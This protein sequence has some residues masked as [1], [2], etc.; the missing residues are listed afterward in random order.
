[1]GSRDVGL[2]SRHLPVRRQNPE[3]P[4]MNDQAIE[5]EI[6]AKGLTAARVTKD[7]IDALMARVTYV[8]GRVEQT[9]S[10]IVH[11]FLDGGFLLASGHSAC[12]SPENF[13]AELGF[14]MARDQAEVK[15]RDQL[16]LL[17]GY[18]LRTRLGEPV[19]M[20][21]G[22]L[23][24]DLLVNRF[25]QWPVPAHIHPDGTPGQPGR[26]GTNLLDAVT[27]GDM[28]RHVLGG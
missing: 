6:Q 11:A 10:T 24:P 8:G 15:A 13:N 7:H 28:L 12:V 14:N 26:T 23:D 9:T 16:W 21:S 18:A 20:V 19:A 17:E 4:T 25:L 1:M 27:A 5:L 22:G 3:R 2:I